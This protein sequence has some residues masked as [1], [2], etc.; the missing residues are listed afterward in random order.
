MSVPVIA[1]KDHP[2]FREFLME[3]VTEAFYSRVVATLFIFVVSLFAVSFPTLS[4][5]ISVLRIPRIIFFIGKHFGTGWFA[6]NDTA[7]RI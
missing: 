7:A 5:R 6:V 3:P 4:K 1:G 2:C